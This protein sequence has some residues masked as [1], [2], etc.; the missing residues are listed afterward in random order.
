[1]RDKKTKY[2]IYFGHDE[3]SSLPRENISRIRE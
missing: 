3:S 1:M 2:R